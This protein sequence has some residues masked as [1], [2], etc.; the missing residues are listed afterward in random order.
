MLKFESKVDLCDKCYSWFTSKKTFI[1][2]I[3][4]ADTNYKIFQKLTIDEEYRVIND[5]GE[6]SWEIKEQTFFVLYFKLLSPLT[7]LE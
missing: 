5:E 7:W 3:P 6:I 4:L 1:R 2:R